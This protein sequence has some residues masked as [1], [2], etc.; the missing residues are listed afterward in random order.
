MIRIDFSGGS[1]WRE[2]VG[3]SRKRGGKSQISN[4][5]FQTNGQTDKGKGQ[6]GKAGTGGMEG[7]TE[8]YES[9]VEPQMTRRAADQMRCDHGLQG[10]ERMG[11][12]QWG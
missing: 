6:N 12:R 9:R 1:R 10:R 3:N 2:G 5:K 8:E 7:V 4:P 11:G